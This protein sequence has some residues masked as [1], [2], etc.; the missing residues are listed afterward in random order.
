MQAPSDI[1]C[2]RLSHYL[3]QL[4]PYESTPVRS[5]Y[6]YR[7]VYA[8]GNVKLSFMVWAVNDANVSSVAFKN[9]TSPIIGK[10]IKTFANKF[11]QPH[12]YICLLRPDVDLTM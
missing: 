4:L 9:W 8:D 5:S 2:D 12:L 6:Q 11:L 7:D 1:G 3:S 10:K